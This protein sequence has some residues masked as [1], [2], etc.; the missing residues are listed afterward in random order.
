MPLILKEE[1]CLNNYN[2]TDLFFF[3]ITFIEYLLLVGEL[4]FWFFTTAGK[5]ELVAFE[6]VNIWLPAA[7]R[8]AD[9]DMLPAC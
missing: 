9:K 3:L 8:T 5:I 6:L 2:A 7:D 4:R 1:G